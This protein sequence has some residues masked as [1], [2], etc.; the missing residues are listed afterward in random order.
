MEIEKP[1]SKNGENVILFYL[2]FSLAGVV[3][4]FWNS[5]NTKLLTAV[6]PK[7]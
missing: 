1:E 6:T 4:P 2:K 7:R 3:V 5:W